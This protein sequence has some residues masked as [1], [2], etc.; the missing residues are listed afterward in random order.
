[1][2]ERRLSLGLGSRGGGSPGF[3]LDIA[4]PLEEVALILRVHFFPE[5]LGLAS[6]VTCT[7]WPVSEK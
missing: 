7:N 3:L 6:V 4:R 2:D 5:P 1:M